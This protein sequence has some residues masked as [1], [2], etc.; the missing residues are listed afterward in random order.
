MSDLLAKALE[1]ARGRE[2]ELLPKLR[3]WVTTNSFSGNTDGVNCMG[4]LLLKDFDLPELS[5]E[6]RAG[7]DV[8]DHLFW[9]T[10][11]WDQQPERRILLVGHH[12]TVFPPGTFEVWEHEGDRLRGPGVLDMK[13]G[14]AILHHALQSLSDAGALADIAVGFVCVGDEEIGS[15]DSRPWVESIAEGAS[16]ALVF[17]A[18]RAEDVIITQR[19]GTGRFHV[20]VTGKAAHAG[21]YHADGVNSI[22]AL[23]QFIDQAQRFTDYERGVTVN[24]GTIE[25]G[26]SANTVP[27][28][29]SCMVDFRF[30]TLDDGQA[31][32]GRFDKLAR[33]VAEATSA[34]FQLDGGIRRSPLERTDAS[35]AVYR[36]Y[37][38]CAKQAGLGDGECDLLGGGSDASTVSAIGVPAIDGLGPRGFGFHTHDEYIEVSSLMLR[39]DALLRFLLSWKGT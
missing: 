27:A 20:R 19:K 28:Q 9:R 11:A 29:A 38:A 22:W 32:V 36:H 10:A 18:G 4:E 25:G 15:A 16:C 17:E 5:V 21:N 33:E 39:V 14:V 23:A 12:D 2:A 7:V 31:L 37:A 8:G 24:V 13:G 3:R 30:V 34:R 1:A 26:S 6:R 35:V